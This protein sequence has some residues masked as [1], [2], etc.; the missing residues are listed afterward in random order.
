M[1]VPQGSILSVT[2][3]SVK[4]NSITQCLKPGVDC[5]LYVD[6]FQICYRSSNISIIE[7][8]LQLCLNKL[9]Q[10]AT[11]NGFRFSKTKTLCMHI[12]QKRGLHLDPQ[13]FL[14]KSPIP[15]VEE[16]KFLGVIFDRK[17]S[18]IPH[19]K[20]VKKKVLKALNILKVIGNTEWGADRK[21]MLRLY[22][23]L[24]RS[25]L[26]YG[27][28]V[29]GSARK[30][31]LQMLDPIHNQGLRLCLGAFQT[32]PVESLYVDAHEPSLGARRAKLSLQYATKIKSLPNHAAHNAVF[33]NT[34]M[35]LFDARPS[36]IP[37]FGLRIKQFLTASNIELSD[38][39][40]PPSYFSSPPWYI[41]PPKI[42]LDLVHLKKDQT[43]ASIYQQLF[44][45]IRDRYRDHIPVYTDGSR[46][47]I[48]VAC[49]TV[50]PSDIT[51][52]MRLPDSAS[53][54]TAEIWQSLKPWKKL[55]M[56]LHPNL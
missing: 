21:V 3:F 13:L 16:T 4:I 50:F 42:V 55:K 12:C 9:Q 30:S 26:D 31:Y 7:R 17:L 29:Y 40:E 23:S 10:W 54:F 45:E 53:I 11:D 28:I 15:V 20:Y 33:D 14:D 56:H 19:L 46:D 27:C 48:S 38:I 49:A 47:G 24:I 39:L 43:D 5:S 35:K 2:L 37:T 52:S 44:M 34:Y 6:D 36:A 41:K 22:R 8:Q 32:I 18:F 25:K 1:G 51:F